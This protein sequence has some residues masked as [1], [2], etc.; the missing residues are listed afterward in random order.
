MKKYGILISEKD[1]TPAFRSR[2]ETKKRFNSEG[3]R[4]EYYNYLTRP[5]KPTI[6]DL[7]CANDYITMS[8]TRIE[9][10]Q[11]PNC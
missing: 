5:R 11:T 3:E 10:D 8:Y 7:L 1:D 2:D 6:D 4:D 9:E